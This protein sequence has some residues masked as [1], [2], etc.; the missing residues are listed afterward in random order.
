[1]S[2]GSSDQ[3]WGLELGGLGFLSDGVPRN[4]ECFALCIKLINWCYSVNALEPFLVLIQTIKRISLDPS[5][6]Q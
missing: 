2:Q 4:S 1:M 3:P 5:M 6:H